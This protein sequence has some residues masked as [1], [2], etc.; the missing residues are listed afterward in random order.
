MKPARTKRGHAHSG[1][2]RLAMSYTLHD[3][4]SARVT[5][6]YRKVFLPR[7]PDRHQ[8]AGCTQGVADSGCIMYQTCNSLSSKEETGS[9][10]V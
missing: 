2:H 4:M 6:V 7:E 8:R 1:W 9:H 3:S 5:V 10:K